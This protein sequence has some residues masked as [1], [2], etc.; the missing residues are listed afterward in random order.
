VPGLALL[1]LLVTAEPVELR[2]VNLQA[3]VLELPEGRAAKARLDAAREK[4]QAKIDRRKRRL[5][6]ARAQLEEAEL[7]E[8]SRALEAEID[9]AEEAL[10]GLQ[11]GLL[12]PLLAKLGGLAEAMERPGREVVRL[13][14]A[15][16]LGWPEVCDLTSQLLARARGEEAEPIAP[17]SA[18]RAEKFRVVE[19]APLAVASPLAREASARIEALRRRHQARIDRARAEVEALEAKAS[20]DPE[21]AES[22]RRKRAALDRRVEALR[23]TLAERKARAEARVL[24]T[25]AR[26]LGEAAEALDGV[27]VVEK[28]EQALPL[29]AEDGQ[30]WAREVLGLPDAGA[31]PAP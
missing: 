26:R 1:T 28:T 11:S 24:E 21:L 13:D 9:A 14:Q 31:R 3:A 25:L 16:L 8:R 6:A 29:P 10:E 12:A 17:A 2:Y 5:L 23:S 18:C 20:R 27:A 22:A 19:L 30:Q 15:P 4:A 7:E